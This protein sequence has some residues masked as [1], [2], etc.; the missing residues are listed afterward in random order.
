M[1]EFIKRTYKI[2]F[3]GQEAGLLIFLSLLIILTF[4]YLGGYL[5]PFFISVFIAFLL[6]EFVVVLKNKNIPHLVAVSLT[7]LLFCIVTAILLLLI[8]PLIWQRMVDF[9]QNSPTLI[10]QI[11]AWLY[12]LPE[13]YPEI[14]T[15]GDIDNFVNTIK[16]NIISY[17]QTIISSSLTSIGQIGQ[18]FVYIVIVLVLVFFILKD[19]DKLTHSLIKLLPQENKIMSRLGKKMKVE[20]LRYISCKL[21]EGLIVFV[22]AWI[23]F[24]ILGLNFST[25]LAISAGVSVLIPYVGA[26]IV[27]VPVALV[28]YSQFGAE[29]MFFYV[30]LAY[31]ILQMLDGYLLVP[32]LFSEVTNLHPVS[33]ILA[34]IIF[35]SLWGLW[36]IAFAI[37]LATFIKALVQYWP[38]QQAERRNS[39]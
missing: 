12:L 36:G 5:V 2:Y 29:P 37:P 33:V 17:G 14:F 9:I 21:L 4:Y 22:V 3:A 20:M 27:T 34:I 15:R 6:N 19:Y 10:E 23:T 28:A 8:L 30:L 11:S 13:N 35:G 18:V 32:I 16:E 1:W 38:K 26:V 25:I 24:A 39:R 31:L 7:F